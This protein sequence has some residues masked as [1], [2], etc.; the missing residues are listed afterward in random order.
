MPSGYLFPLPVPTK[1]PSPT[2]QASAAALAAANS[3]LHPAQGPLAPLAHAAHASRLGVG[4]PWADPAVTTHTVFSCPGTPQQEQQLVADLT[5]EFSLQANQ[6]AGQGGPIASSPTAAAVGVSGAS[7]ATNHLISSPTSLLAA[8]SLDQYVEQS[9]L[10]SPAGSRHASRP[11]TPA[12]GPSAGGSSRGLSAAA[13]AR[14]AAQQ[15]MLGG[16]LSPRATSRVAGTEMLC[17]RACHQTFTG[18]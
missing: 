10:G 8:L 15:L 4:D 6:G 3:H 7:L 14:K 18:T 12:G 2:A 1:K 13:V 16:V 17:S 5:Q 9:P 11:T